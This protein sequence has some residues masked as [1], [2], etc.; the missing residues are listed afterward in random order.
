MNTT[1]PTVTDV[2]DITPDPRNTA[3]DTVDVVF[4]EPINLS[5]FTFEDVIL[6]HDSSPVTLTGAITTSLVSG[7]TYR[8]SG[9]SSFTS[10]NGDYVLTVDAS[11]IQD[12]AGN[13]G[14]GSASDTWTMNSSI[15]MSVLRVDTNAAPG[16]DGLAWITAY[17]N[18]QEALALATTLNGDGNSANDVHQIWIAEGTY[19]PTTEL[20]PGDPRSASFSL[21]NG[22]T[23]YGGFVG[24]ETTLDHRNWS[25]HITTLSGDLGTSGDNSDNTHTVVYCG[26]GIEARVNGISIIGGNANGSNI[27]N[28]PERLYGGGIYNSGTLTVTNSMLSD[29]SA[30]DGGGI[31]SCSGTLVVMDSTLANNSA[32]GSSYGLG[33]GIYSCSSTLMVTNSILSGNLGSYGGGIA[34]DGTLII[35]NSTL[36]ANLA[37]SYGGGIYIKSGSSIATLN[38]TIVA[39]NGAQSEYGLDIRLASG[40]LSGSCNLI[41][42]GSGQSTLI[43]GIDGNQVGNFS[44]PIDPMLS[45]WTELVNGQWGYYLLPGSPAI[46][47]GENILAVDTVGQPLAED[48]YGNSRIQNGTVDIGAVE[49]AMVGSPAQ[50]Y[51]V[52]S[53]A[54]TISEDGVLTFAEAFQAANRNQ[55][56]GDAPAGSFGEQDVIQFAEG[57]NGTILV[58]D[59][60]LVIEGDLG[61][62]GLGAKLLS[63]NAEGENRVFR[64]R[65]GAAVLLSGVTITGGLADEGGGIYNSGSLTVVNSALSGNSAYR[66]GGA[67]CSF[68]SSSMLMVVNST[69]SYNSAAGSGGG[70]F[71]YG[72]MTVACSTLTDNSAKG[73]YYSYGGGI[74]NNGTLTVTN[75][76]LLGNLVSS[77]SGVGIY[78]YG[79]GICSWG[80]LT[81]TNSTLLGNSASGSSYS[82]GGGICCAGSSTTTLNNTIVA[83]NT[84]PTG[85]NVCRVSVSGTLSGSYNLIGDGSGQSALVD[86]VDGNQVGTSAAPIDPMLSEMYR[87]LPG[88]PVIEAG[89]N[90]LAVDAQGTPLAVDLDGNPRISGPSVDIGAYEYQWTANAITGQAWNDEDQDGAWDEGELGLEGWTVGISRPGGLGRLLTTIQKPVPVEGDQFGLSVAGVGERILVGAHRDDQGASNAGAAYLFDAVTGDV[91]L[92]FVNP[93]PDENDY[94]GQRVASLGDDVLIAAYMGDTGAQDAGSAYLFDGTTGGLLQTFERPTAAAYDYF[95]GALAG[96]GDW[97]LVG[98]V[99]VDTTAADAGAAYLFNATTGDLVRTFENPAPS[100]TGFFGASLAWVGDDVLIGAP[101]NDANA[102]HAGAAY[103]FD[104][105]TGALLQTFLDP[106]PGANGWFGNAVAAVGGNVLVGTRYGEAAYLFDS[107]TGALLQTFVNPQPTTN[108]WFGFSLA[109]VGDDVLIGAYGTD[110]ENADVGAA[111][112]FDSSTGQLLRTFQNPDPTP[113]ACFGYS[114][115]SVGNQ[116][117]IGA[118][119]SDLGAADAGAAYLFDAE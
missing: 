88:S 118:L 30:A 72:T 106:T 94:F 9:L 96:Q 53:L 100:S 90:E 10:I 108:D 86:G 23:L 79:G 54:K 111:Y 80:T 36:S 29:N 21:V 47:A 39:G 112:L 55:P 11:G 33:G 82:Y 2:V 97:V 110:G 41:G 85:P 65:V 109:A 70:I 15:D 74:C 12:L 27:S 51:V 18:L 103:L 104:A 50:I 77:Y 32:A 89:S 20:E 75:S 69:L 16:G 26:A 115:A 59:H 61:I 1:P 4:S 107:T 5:T 25:A 98:A 92:S 117:L 3:V 71:N 102:S 60:E 83:A 101:S 40:T 58:N 91:V 44:S 42:D 66:E 52:G 114:V 14:T 81:V 68:G 56:V 93:E 99:G 63:F 45:D 34:S 17:N 84:A 57:L 8:I 13:S 35:T 24:T 76:M 6:T 28:H 67:I 73:F 37:G 95:G 31:Y 49:G 78:S 87:P 105:E 43:H 48:I 113:S 22:V 62:E 7:T 38:N 119:H 46:D 19:K 64:I 116:V